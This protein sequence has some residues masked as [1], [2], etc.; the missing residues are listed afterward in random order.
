MRE[1]GVGGDGVPLSPQGRPERSRPVSDSRGQGPGDQP[2]RG[3]ATLLSITAGQTKHMRAGDAQGSV[4]VRET[5]TRPLV[6]KPDGSINT[7]GSAFPRQGNRAPQ[8]MKDSCL[9]QESSFVF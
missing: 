2:N 3:S 1:G 8:W 7:S 9:E 5:I 4:A 6:P